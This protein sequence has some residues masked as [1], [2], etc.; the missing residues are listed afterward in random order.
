MLEAVDAFGKN[1]GFLE[2]LWLWCENCWSSA[3]TIQ[4]IVMMEM[5][6]IYLHCP[7]W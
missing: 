5:F 3:G 2:L 4:F 1:T 6:Y 7:E